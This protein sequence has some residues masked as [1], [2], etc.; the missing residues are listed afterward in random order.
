MRQSPEARYVPALRFSWLTPFYDV[1][2]GTT[3]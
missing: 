3:T 2:I 1:V